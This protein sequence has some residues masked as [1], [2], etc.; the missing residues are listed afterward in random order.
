M[1]TYQRDDE[2]EGTLDPGERTYL[3]AGAFGMP[4]R[5]RALRI[6]HF[7]LSPGHSGNSPLPASIAM[8]AD[9]GSAKKKPR[10]KMRR[11]YCH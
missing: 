2:A 1:S 7:L 8:S 5:E 4:G 9:E 3:L 6:D 11:G 10:Y